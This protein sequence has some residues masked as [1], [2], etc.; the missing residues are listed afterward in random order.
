MLQAINIGPA[1]M[2]V[3]EHARLVGNIRSFSDQPCP[4]VAPTGADL[5]AA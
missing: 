2:E 4:E 5:S 3:W 1:Q